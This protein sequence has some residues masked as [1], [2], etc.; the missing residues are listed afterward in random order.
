[1]RGPSPPR[2]IPLKQYL[3]EAG[4]GEQG[5]ETQFNPPLKSQMCLLART[6]HSAQTKTLYVK[7]SVLLIITKCEVTPKCGPYRN[8]QQMRHWTPIKAQT[9][10]CFTHVG[11]PLEGGAV[12][13]LG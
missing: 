10:Q 8:V 7:H 4:E 13:L 9:A 3:Q 6:S 2:Q 5:K 1:M 12:L 11:P